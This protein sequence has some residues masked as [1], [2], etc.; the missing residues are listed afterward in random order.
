MHEN[1]S[2]GLYTLE[3]EIGS[4]SFATVW[5]GRHSLTGFVVAVKVI[6]KEQM[7][8]NFPHINFEREITFMKEIEHPFIATLYEVIEDEFRYYLVMEFAD[9]GNL[10]DYVNSNGRLAEELAKKFFSQI[11]SSLVHLHLVCKVAHRD[12]KCE[13]ILLDK[14]DNVRLIDFGLSNSFTDGSPQMNTTCGSPAYAAPEMVLGQSYNKSADIWSTGV[15]LYAIVVGHLPFE[16][17]SVRRLLNLILY[18]DVKYPS[19]L[20]PLL[21]DL[22]KKMLVRD[23]NERITL[24]QIQSHPWFMKTDISDFAHKCRSFRC[25]NDEVDIEVIKEMGQFGFG[26]QSTLETVSNKKDQK[27][28]SIYKMVSRFILLERIKDISNKPV[29]DDHKTFPP[30]RR[31]SVPVT[32]RL[33]LNENKKHFCTTTNNALASPQVKIQVPKVVKMR[34]NSINLSTHQVDQTFM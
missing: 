1:Y 16:D 4:G 33:L 10:L 28:V 14:Y 25:N 17:K 5:K 8:E 34:R 2:L 19:F 12:I 20:S 24:D 11:I 3:K 26:F 29:I 7:K 22:L 18:A 6:E 15:L 23:P 21:V 31:P 9:H 27:I 32:Q 13:N 30:V